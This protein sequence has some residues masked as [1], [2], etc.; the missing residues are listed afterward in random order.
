MCHCSQAAIARKYLYLYLP[1]L[2][3][4]LDYATMSAMAQ[5]LWSASPA[6]HSGVG[7]IIFFVGQK[8]FGFQKYQTFSNKLLQI[9]VHHMQ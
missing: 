4:T 3:T 6:M 2:L 8:I 9:K 7:G 1:M 5:Q